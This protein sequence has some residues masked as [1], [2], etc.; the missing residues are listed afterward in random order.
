[1]Q[2]IHLQLN[3][4]I[5]LLPKSLSYMDM[6]KWIEPGCALYLE[7]IACWMA[8][9]RVTFRQ[10]SNQTLP[11]KLVYRTEE[12]SMFSFNSR[13]NIKNQAQ[14]FWKLPK[15]LPKLSFPANRLA[16]IA[17]KV[18]KK[19]CLVLLIIQKT[20]KNIEHTGTFKRLCDIWIM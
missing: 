20:T 1:M 12:N 10:S 14:N 4:K 3:I 5:A 7:Q 19:A 11:Y 16:F 6:T 9:L 13:E 2:H 15:F 17:A 18:S 8:C